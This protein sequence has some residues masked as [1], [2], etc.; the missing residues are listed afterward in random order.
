MK[1]G[2]R[3]S[4]KIA[5]CDDMEWVRNGLI[6]NIKEYYGS[7]DLEIEEFEDGEDLIEEFKLG[8]YDLIFLDYYMKRMNGRATADAIRKID[9]KVMI[10]FA[11]SED[12]SFFDE[13]ASLRVD[14]P[15][16]RK[17]YDKIME[18]YDKRKNYPKEMYFYFTENGKKK[19]RFVRS[20]VYIHDRDIYL[21][22]KHITSDEPVVI[23][24][25]EKFFTTRNGYQINMGH[26][27][28]LEW[29]KVL[30]MGLDNPEIGWLDYIQLKK[31]LKLYDKRN[32]KIRLC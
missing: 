14:K 22:Y 28:K 26:I 25:E 19:C 7:G 6:E 3:Y 20:I 32:G 10:V 12:I 21:D 23:K 31:S 13:T 2:R 4:L 24:N 11:T 27:R 30:F 9:Q 16:K 29:C 1:I 15:L 5:I 8:K 17:D 18:I